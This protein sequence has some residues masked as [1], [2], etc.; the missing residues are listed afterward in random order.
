VSLPAGSPSANYRIGTTNRIGNPRPFSSLLGHQTGTLACHAVSASSST[1]GHRGGPSNGL[2]GV[3]VADRCIP[4]ATAAYGTWVARGEEH[5]AHAWRRRLRLGRRMRSVLGDH[6]LV[7]KSPE[8]SRQ[9]G[10]PARRGISV[11]PPLQ[12]IRRMVTDGSCGA[13]RVGGSVPHGFWPGGR[14][15]VGG[16]VDHPRRSGK[17]VSGLLSWRLGPGQ[18]GCDSGSVSA[19]WM[20]DVAGMLGAASVGQASPA[21]W[22]SRA[23]WTR[24]L[25]S[26]FSNI[27]ETCALTVATLM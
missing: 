14:D 10:C 20:W 15:D 8:G 13:G 1:P 2:L 11:G 18:S 16:R 25:N 19:T 12:I 23:I 9:G 24:L 3:T 6:C 4:L 5:D 17:D 21:S 27:R 22:A 7:G 26:S